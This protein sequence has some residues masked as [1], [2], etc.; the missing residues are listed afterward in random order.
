MYKW[1]LQLYSVAKFNKTTISLN[2][3]ESTA[4]FCNKKK[5]GL[6]YIINYVLVAMSLIVLLKLLPSGVN[7][8]PVDAVPRGSCKGITGTTIVSYWHTL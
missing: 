3:K 7:Y 4:C 6:N 2:N 8:T 1:N 5:K